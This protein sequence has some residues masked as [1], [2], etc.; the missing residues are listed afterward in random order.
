MIINDSKFQSQQSILTETI[1]APMLVSQSS[2]LRTRSDTNQL[3]K[4]RRWL[5]AGNFIFR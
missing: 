1:G 2:G 4:H 5:E 3:Y